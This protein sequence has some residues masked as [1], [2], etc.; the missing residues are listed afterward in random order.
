MTAAH[1]AQDE[2]SQVRVNLLR[3][4]R[5]IESSSMDWTVIESEEDTERESAV[6]TMMIKWV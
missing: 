2:S 3:D 4:E 1:A 5:N 6:F